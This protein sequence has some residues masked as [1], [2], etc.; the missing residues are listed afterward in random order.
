METAILVLL[1]AFGGLAIA[2]AVFRPSAKRP[3]P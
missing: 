1:F 3:G 2:S